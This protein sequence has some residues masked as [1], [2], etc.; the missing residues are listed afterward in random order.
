[1]LVGRCHIAGLGGGVFSAVTLLGS[2]APVEV[3]DRP[4]VGA[5]DGDDNDRSGSGGA[6]L[7]GER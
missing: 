3:I 2:A 7:V 5:G 1:M 6:V 4:V